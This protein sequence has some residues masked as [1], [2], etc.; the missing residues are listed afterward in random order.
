MESVD[1]R[2]VSH[3]DFQVLLERRFLL[4]R[5]GEEPLVLELIQAEAKGS[6]EPEPGRRR[7]FALVFR[8]PQAPI[9][10]QAIY[11]LEHAELG[12][13]EIFLVPLGPNGDGI[14]YEAVFA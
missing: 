4:A 14:G 1:L 13:L 5:E 7:P 10:A 6:G 2:S 9:L 8:G 12:R 11:A 3:E